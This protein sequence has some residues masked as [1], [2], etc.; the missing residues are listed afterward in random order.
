MWG[1]RGGQAE[2]EQVDQGSK[3]ESEERASED[4]I[5]DTTRRT[6]FPFSPKRGKKKKSSDWPT[7]RP[8]AHR[9][10]RRLFPP[11]PPWAASKPPDQT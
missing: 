7:A 4:D 8:Q 2:S 6:A 10:G 5:W 3:E 9:L 1:E 11:P